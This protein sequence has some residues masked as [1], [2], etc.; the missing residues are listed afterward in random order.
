MLVF[1][2]LLL[3]F[4]SLI[5][6]AELLQ[7]SVDELPASKFVEAL[8]NMAEKGV[9]INGTLVNATV[10]LKNTTGLPLKC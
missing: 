5:V 7:S 6:N 2:L 10:T 1:S 3:R 4:G 8:V 9:E